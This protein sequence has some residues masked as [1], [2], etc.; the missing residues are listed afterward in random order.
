L[1]APDFGDQIQSEKLS[2]IKLSLVKC[3]NMTYIL[4]IECTQNMAFF[5]GKVLLR[6]FATMYREQFSYSCLMFSCHLQ[7]IPDAPSLL[8]VIP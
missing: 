1:S 6:Y 3:T 5:L 2:E 4:Q 7:R 8:I